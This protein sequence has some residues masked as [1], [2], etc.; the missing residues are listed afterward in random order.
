MVSFLFF[1]PLIF[2]YLGCVPRRGIAGLFILLHLIFWGIPKLFSTMDAP[3]YIPISSIWAF[4]FNILIIYFKLIIYS[5]YCTFQCQNFYL[6]PLAFIFSFSRDGELARCESLGPSRAFSEH[7]S[8]CGHKHGLLD[9]L[10]P[11]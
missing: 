9:F 11:L 4:W 10:S 6:V 8:H 3:F 7:P 2:K 1:W 5:H